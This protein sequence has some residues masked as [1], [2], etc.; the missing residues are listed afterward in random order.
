MFVVLLSI[1]EPGWKIT[2]FDLA[3]EGTSRIAYTTHHSRGTECYRAPELIRELSVFS[4]K[5]DIFALGCILYELVTGKKVFPREFYLFEYTN[6]RRMPE[7]TLPEEMN[8]RMASYL[9]QFIHSMLQVDWWR[10][11]PTRDILRLLSMLVE[12]RDEIWSTS[13][14]G[15]CSRLV[16]SPNW[17]ILWKSLLWVPQWSFPNLLLRCALLMGLVNNVTQ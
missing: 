17:N 12:G 8:D 13:E 11:P 5:S 15:I 3:S 7:I 14:S 4:M 16:A 1:V 9:T 6:S 2:D 10:R